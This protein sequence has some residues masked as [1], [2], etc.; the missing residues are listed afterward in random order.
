[1]KIEK[2]RKEFSPREILIRMIVFLEYCK[3]NLSEVVWLCCY[4][5]PH[6]ECFFCSRETG[7]MQSTLFCECFGFFFSEGLSSIAYS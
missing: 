4:F 3:L 7:G 2:K 5:R 6:M 1:M